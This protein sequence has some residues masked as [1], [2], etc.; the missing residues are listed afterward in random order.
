[1]QVFVSYILFCVKEEAHLFMINVFNFSTRFL[2]YY[3]HSNLFSRIPSHPISGCITYIERIKTLILGSERL[4][5]IWLRTRDRRD[6][7]SEGY[8]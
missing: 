1:M 8:V 4:V 7:F 6:R 5:Y 2:V 3:N